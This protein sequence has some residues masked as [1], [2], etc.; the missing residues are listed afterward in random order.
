MSSQPQKSQMRNRLGILALFVLLTALSGAA[1]YA[2]MQHDRQN[3]SSSHVNKKSSQETIPE[4]VGAIGRLEPG[5]KIY[6]VSPSTGPEGARVEKLTVHEGEQIE[7]NSV[8]AILDTRTRRQASVEEAKAQV[9]MSKAKLA[10]VKAGVKV[11]DIISQEA[12]VD[13]LKGS[14]QKAQAEYDR[15]MIV[16][17]SGALSVEE[18]DQRS[19]QLQIAK[20]ALRQAEATVAGL[21]KIRQEDLAVAEAEVAKSKAGLAHAEADLETTQIRAP[22]SGRVLKLYAMAGE[23][24]GEK[25]LLEL[26]DTANMHAVAEVYEKDIQRV[27]LGQ[28]AKIR[29]QS[30]PAYV[31]SITN[32]MQN[33][34]SH[35][36]SGEVVQIGWKVG[37]QVVFDNDPVKDTDARVVEVR[38]KLSPE[39]SIR[40]AGLSYARVEIYIDTNGA[41]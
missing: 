20:A 11:E 35:D 25:G 37:R 28:Q 16:R 17:S 41:R 26:G 2:K 34:S 5:W 8:L 23:K 32:E 30:L 22:I 7:M 29:V 1:W 24:I 19:F 38:I 13:Q 21:K 40:V 15:A 31:S 6:Q 27:R 10:Q 12:L 4:G 33:Q 18:Y 3:S 36:L 39:A 14:L 9:L